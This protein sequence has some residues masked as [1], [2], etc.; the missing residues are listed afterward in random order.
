MEE[1]RELLLK[2]VNLKILLNF[3]L[4][5]ITSK[6]L[7]IKVLKFNQEYKSKNKLTMKRI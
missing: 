6:K 7:R 3:Y 5:R 1:L 2:R 4:S